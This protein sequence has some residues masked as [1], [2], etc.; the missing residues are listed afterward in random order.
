[1]ADHETRPEPEPEPEPAPPRSTPSLLEEDSPLRGMFRVFR[2]FLVPFILSWALA[3]TGSES[4]LEWMYYTGL[5]GV[6]VSMLYLMLWL[7]R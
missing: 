1:M 3:W 6:G 5:G 7:I 2:I 4:E